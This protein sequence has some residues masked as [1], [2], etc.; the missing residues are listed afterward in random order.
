MPGGAS[1]GAKALSGLLKS[2]ALILLSLGMAGMAHAEGFQS[3]SGNI[4]CLPYDN[5]MRCDIAQTSNPPPPRPADCDLD[6]GNAFWVGASSRRAERACHGDT[7]SGRYPALAYGKT[8]TRY[9][10][11][12]LSERKGISCRNRRGAGFF[13][14]RAV[15]RVF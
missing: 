11:T 1:C 14:S 15:Q 6:W 9:G 3:P 7:A 10:V 5:G 12:C 2:A 4:M 8:F 13:L